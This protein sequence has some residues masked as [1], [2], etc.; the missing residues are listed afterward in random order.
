VVTAVIVAFLAER[1][2][3]GDHVRHGMRTAG[4]PGHATVT[5]TAGVIDLRIRSES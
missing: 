4:L 3:V 1:L 5:V 2:D